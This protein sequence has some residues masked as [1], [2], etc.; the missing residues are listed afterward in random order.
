MKDITIYII[1][2]VLV[3]A[4]MI[5]QLLRGNFENVFMCV[6]TLILFLTKY[7]FATFKFI[8]YITNDFIIN[9]NYIHTYR[10]KYSE[11]IIYF[12]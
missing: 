2:R 1:L 11:F 3:I 10:N 6:L 7:Q 8:Y 4:T 12:F 9:W 5:I